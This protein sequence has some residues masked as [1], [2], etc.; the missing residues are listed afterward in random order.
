MGKD[1]YSA[2]EQGLG[3]IY[4]PRL[5][6]LKMLDL[7]ENFA[8]LIEGDDDLEFINDNGERSLASL[9]HKAKGDKI[10]D[11]ATDFWKSIR[12]WLERYANSGKVLSPLRFF[13]F[14]TASVSER[15]FLRFFL[16]KSPPLVEPLIELVEAAISS[17]TSK[18]MLSVRTVFD[19]LSFSEKEDFISRITIFDKS[20]RITDIPQLIVD[21]HLRTIPR[22]SRS[23]VLERLEGWWHNVTINLLSG[24]R[25]EAITGYEVSDKLA[26]IAEEYKSDNLPITFRNRRPTDPIDAENDPRVFVQQ[27]R[28][29]NLSATRIQHAII[30]YYRAFEQRSSWARESLLIADEM[31]EYEDLL[32]E[33]WS[34][35]KE[36]A[37]EHLNDKSEEDHLQKAGRELLRW[38]E[39]ETER[40]R[41]RERVT[42]PYVVRGAFHILAN[43]RPTPRV[44][45]HP[46]FEERIKNVLE[47]AN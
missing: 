27:L 14:T 5:A 21:R 29:L 42:E 43:D 24:E 8:V 38:A 33:E 46:N 6:L 26:A 35:F 1:K 37:F 34:R 10:T 47:V 19:D 20:P 22:S 45:W 7:P 9:K 18:T 39:F 41:I 36:V 32:V 2:S 23:Q 40:F 12:I 44:Y 17:S 30:D 3:Y 4:Q 11:L 13:L 31:E 28:F 16:Q 25:T 15:T